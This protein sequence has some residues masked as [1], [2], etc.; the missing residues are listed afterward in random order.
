V[1]VLVRPSSSS[2]VWVLCSPEIAVRDNGPVR[3]DRGARCGTG[4][5]T[6]TRLADR[7]AAGSR[8]AAAR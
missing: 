8:A 3:E 2:R 4:L 7:W 1:R 6:V 5:G